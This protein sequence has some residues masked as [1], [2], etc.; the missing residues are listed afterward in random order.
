MDH[1]SVRRVSPSSRRGHPCTPRHT[2]GAT[3][4]G[5]CQKS[6]THGSTAQRRVAGAMTKSRHAS[7]PNS[8]SERGRRAAPRKFPPQPL[9]MVSARSTNVPEQ[10]MEY[11][12]PLE[13]RAEEPVGS[14]WSESEK[15]ERDKTEYAEPASTRVATER[16]RIHGKSVP[17]PLCRM[18]SRQ[19]ILMC[20][21][22][23]LSHEQP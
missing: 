1:L 8:A 4:C 21:G 22:V 15:G 12:Q 17:R 2:R 13:D 19:E 6:R 23:R 7:R 11:I 3:D 14:S 16:S 10:T 9:R 5:A 18:T 20:F